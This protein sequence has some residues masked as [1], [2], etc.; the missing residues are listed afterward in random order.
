MP[1]PWVMELFSWMMQPFLGVR[2]PM[3]LGGENISFYDETM[4][5]G[6]DAMFLCDETIIPGDTTMPNER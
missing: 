6:D 5:V 3:S 2:K 4:P 1:G